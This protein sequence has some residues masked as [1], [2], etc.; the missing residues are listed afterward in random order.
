MLVLLQ[1]SVCCGGSLFRKGVQQTNGTVCKGT[2]IYSTVPV[3]K[4]PTPKLHDLVK[5]LVIEQS[6]AFSKGK[7]KIEKDSQLDAAMKAFVNFDGRDLNARGK[8]PGVSLNAKYESDNEASTS[9]TMKIT[10]TIKAEVVEVL[11]NGNLVIEATK[12]RVVNQE[13]EMITLTGVIDPD[14]MDATGSVLSDDVARL[15][16][17]YTGTG[18]VSDSQKRG[19]LGRV[20]DF[21]WPF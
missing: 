4:P 20:L 2:T 3:E 6:S 21:L 7:T 16:V 5:V 13:N 19:V 17:S 12:T 15:K 9:K 11:P 1:T 8:L 14:D 10:A 18:S